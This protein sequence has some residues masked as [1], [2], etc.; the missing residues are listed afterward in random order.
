MYTKKQGNTQ[1][2]KVKNRKNK[3]EDT[4]KKCEKYYILFIRKQL[5]YIFQG[6]IAEI[7]LSKV[8]KV[9]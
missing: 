6:K 4:R 2:S 9:T 1:Q 8:V 5:S 7:W 3:T